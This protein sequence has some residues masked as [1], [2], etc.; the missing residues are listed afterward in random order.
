MH[1]EVKQ[2]IKQT[3]KIYPEFFYLSSVI[4]FGS[5]NINGSPRKYFWFCDYTGIDLAP[6]RGVDITC[7]A[8]LYE[9]NKA[10]CVVST[11]ML[12]HDEHWEQSLHKMFESLIGGGLLL[13][14]CA[15]PLRPEHGTKRTEP[16]CSPFTTDYYRNITKNDF[17]HILPEELFLNY[18]LK[19]ERHLQDLMFR[20]IKKPTPVMMQ[21]F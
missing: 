20:G 12:E 13:I 5:Q 1:K 14:T 17:K 19:Y 21:N 7:P 4:E 8:H 9:G 6:G 3:R 15:G 18:H 10:M 16:W 11:E 2:F